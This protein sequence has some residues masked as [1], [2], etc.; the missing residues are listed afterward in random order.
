M[1]T[2]RGSYQHSIDH[3][4][5]VSIPARFRKSLS[6]R[7]SATFVIVRGLETCVAIY[8]QDE[9]KRMEERLRSR[10]FYDETN[11]RFLRTMTMD[12]DDAT[13]DAQGR[14]AIPPRLL[15]HARLTK[16]A[17][18]NGVIDHLEIW[19]PA[20]F[21]EYLKSSSRSYEDMAGELLL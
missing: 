15:A 7:A 8:P 12:S 17:M 14:V 11:R 10:S 2:F 18:V 1:A 13:L 9:W 6:G 16:E 4:G 19:D 3:K 5:R 21:E 20:Q